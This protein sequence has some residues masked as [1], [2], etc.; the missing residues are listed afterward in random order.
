MDPEASP[1]DLDG[2]LARLRTQVEERRRAG[3]YPPGLEDEL[4]AELAR[5]ISR[6]P[7]QAKVTSMRELLEARGRPP[8]VDP[9]RVAAATTSAFPGGSAIHAAVARVVGHQVAGVLSQVQDVSNALWDGLVTLADALSALEGRQSDSRDLLGLV[10]SL[11]ERVAANER[12]ASEPEVATAELARRVERLEAE[13]AART[14]RPWFSTELR[15][16]PGVAGPGVPAPGPGAPGPG[17]P[18]SGAPDPAGDQA[19]LVAGLEGCEPALV[20]GPATEP[21]IGLLDAIGV[22]G[23]G[24]DGLD[25]VLAL[26]SAPDRSLGAVVAVDLVERLAPQQLLDLVRGAADKLRVGGRLV[27]NATNPRSL[28]GLANG[29]GGRPDRVLVDPGWLALCASEAGFASVEVVWGPLPP[30]DGA[31]RREGAEAEVH[32]VVFRPVS[33]V[34]SALR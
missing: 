16:G 5:I 10:D 22:E 18:D 15:L 9:T 33:Y 28:W 34:L 30:G 31:P 24:A 1:P 3:A 27:A 14:V 19:E 29:A 17:A 20:L 26:A 12:V 7:S 11:V 2:V 6:R 13:A 21:V 23:H 32:R 25:P 4:E 8:G